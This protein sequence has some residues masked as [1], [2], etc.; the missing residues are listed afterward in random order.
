MKNIIK[1]DSSQSNLI[2]SDLS[3]FSDKK[4]V[5]PALPT[6]SRKLLKSKENHLTL[7]SVIGL[8]SN[9]PN[10]IALNPL[11]GEIA[12]PAGSMLV[13]YNPITNK[14]TK[15]IF[16]PNKKPITCV[17]YSKDGKFLIAGEG[18]CKSPEINIWDLRH[19]TP[20][21]CLKGHKFGIE[22]ILFSPNNNYL[23][24]IGDEN[25]KGLFLWDWEKEIK[26]SMNKLSKKIH[27]AVFNPSGTL[28]IT[29]GVQHL[30]FWPFDSE[31]K[32]ILTK[33][34]ETENVFIIEG[35][36]AILGPKFQNKTFMDVSA[37]EGHIYALDTDGVLC[38]LNEQ[39]KLEKWMDLK[40]HTAYTL[41]I[42]PVH[43]ICGCSDGVIRFFD[44]KSLH[45]ITT[46]PKL[47][48]LG[49]YN[50]EKGNIKASTILSGPETFADV[51]ALIMDEPRGRLISLY[52][53]RTLF[54]WDVHDLEKVNVKR[55]FLNHKGTIYDIQT[56]E[57]S[58]YEVT[59]FATGSID[60][61]IRIWNL[62]EEEK[63]MPN[64]P[65]LRRNVYCK[66][67]TRILY[68]GD[69]Y[70]HFKYRTDENES[71]NN[72][73]IRCLRCSHD[74]QYL[75]A[76][77][78]DGVLRIFSLITFT[79]VLEVVSHDQEILCLD[80]TPENPLDVFLLATGSRDRLIHIYNGGE[81]FK[82]LTTL[83]DHNSSIS[84]LQFAYHKA[85]NNILL[86]S[87]GVDKTLIFREYKPKEIK[88]FFQIHL[89][90][91]KMSKFFTMDLN[92]ESNIAVLGQEKKLQ[93]WSIDE[94]KVKGTIETKEE[95]KST[96]KFLPLDNLKISVDSSGTYIAVSNNDK[97]VRIRDFNTGNMVARVSC[98]DIITSLAFTQN[99]KYLI[100]A[101]SKGCIYIWKL[102][103]E[104]KGNIEKKKQQ[105]GLLAK[106]L[107]EVLGKSRDLTL[108]SFWI[109]EEIKQFL[110]KEDQNVNNNNNNENNSVHQLLD[111]LNKTDK[112][113]NN[114]NIVNDFNFQKK[115]NINDNDNKK[116]NIISNRPKEIFQK[117]DEI[118]LDFNPEVS[119][120][121]NN[122]ELP[123]WAQSNI[124]IVNNQE[125]PSWAQSNIKL[126]KDEINISTDI[127]FLN[128]NNLV[129]KIKFS[130][131]LTK[132]TPIKEENSVN[133][134]VINNEIPTWIGD[135]PE[136]NKKINKSDAIVLQ[137]NP[138][139]ETDF[140]EIDIDKDL[141]NN[142]NSKQ[143]IE[144]EEKEELYQK[145][146]NTQTEDPDPFIKK[147]YFDLDK[148]Q[149]N[150]PLRTSLTSQYFKEHSV[151]KPDPSSLFSEEKQY[152]EN[153]EF[154]ESPKKS[155][156]QYI[157]N[158]KKD[159]KPSIFDA[160]EISE[161][162]LLINKNIEQVQ[163]NRGKNEISKTLFDSQVDIKDLEVIQKKQETEKMN[164]STS[165]K[166]DKISQIIHSSKN[167]LVER[168]REAVINKEI[169]Q[170]DDEDLI[171][172]EDDF[173][174]NDDEDDVND[175]IPE[176]KI[177][178][179]KD[180]E[181]IILNE[182]KKN[183][184]LLKENNEDFH[185]M[186]LRTLS[187]VKEQVLMAEKEF[188]NSRK[189][190]PMLKINEKIDFEKKMEAFF[191]DFDIKVK[192][193]KDE[194]DRFIKKEK[195][196]SVKEGVMSRMEKKIDDSK[197][198]LDKLVMRK[199]QNQ[200]I[201][202]LFELDN[203]N[204]NATIE[205]SQNKSISKILLI[206]IFFQYFLI[207]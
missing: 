40:V 44:S 16:S 33:P 179:E 190:S 26:L 91:D 87:C 181:E 55:S 175:M 206:F 156:I 132:E 24:S 148:V 30:K 171:D 4:P 36:T 168:T 141:T 104:I 120:L 46:L 35:K 151:N 153:H 14:Q 185:E 194:F 84:A 90:I 20:P 111:E 98:G 2:P 79:K 176:E 93:L 137:N 59:F 144:P 8:T 81:E 99:S 113:L 50:I 123:S 19:E 139:I 118:L 12:Y 47:P 183:R 201:L 128:N 192:E 121:V 195:K 126:I 85:K 186:I 64:L 125:L 109:E 207:L 29:A 163:V 142:V 196:E 37:L 43:I 154:T 105:L 199:E 131:L 164:V 54:I 202:K 103:Q 58:S 78:L 22:K 187:P 107:K 112:N 57:N 200:N 77:D 158:P 11:S 106:R 45:H 83:E 167:N 122:Q 6:R 147:N 159:K 189:G 21:V 15:F 80:F 48:A 203:S 115:I 161:Q 76:G 27:A 23:V 5:N 169:N 70:E 82:L 102:S 41:Q 68:L 173:E 28:L 13:I 32:I 56:L 160:N 143:V 100:T 42:T 116:N 170:K 89:E 127:A 134:V 149:L 166:N 75:A 129:N 198:C 92:H 162:L 110:K 150:S 174:V 172:F 60:Q 25:D 3:S 204:I 182:S 7:Q 133:D 191:D 39:R 17:T 63:G 184:E 86:M 49:G 178:K 62:L 52:S 114:D 145:I 177:I 73:Q 165:N 157:R 117:P 124:N 136:T 152:P 72:K 71:T 101:S 146:E 38:V 18:V 65:G 140:V 95:D 155:I 94:M 51:I 34:K 67:L 88:P 180:V 130:Q 10:N 9:S 135:N 193:L 96:G 97:V 69:S 53:D 205:N 31:G 188:N 108:D 197:A 1:P 138:L 119:Q 61:T 74:G 66:N